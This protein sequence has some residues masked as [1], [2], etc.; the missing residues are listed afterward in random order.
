M[1]EP[2]VEIFV[3]YESPLAR[4]VAGDIWSGLSRTALG[5]GYARI[6]AFWESLGEGHEATAHEGL[7]VI[8]IF[9]VGQDRPEAIGFIGAERDDGVGESAQSSIYGVVVAVPDRPSP[10][11][12]SLLYQGVG[13]LTDDG[14]KVGS[15]EPALLHALPA[16]CESYAGRLLERLRQRL[17]ES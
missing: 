13:R 1:P 17:R 6:A 15:V 11:A 10:L 16:E 12:G 2:R 4:K 5:A 3:D 9:V 14:V 8:H 7:P